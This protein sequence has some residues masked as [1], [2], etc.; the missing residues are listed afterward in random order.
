MKN[1]A[2]V[3]CENRVSKKVSEKVS[4]KVSDRVSEKMSGLRGCGLRVF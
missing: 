4:E 1:L 2:V 3:E